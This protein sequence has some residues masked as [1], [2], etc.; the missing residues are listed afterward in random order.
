MSKTIKLKKGYDIKL[1]GDVSANTGSFDTPKTYSVKPTDFVGLSPKLKVEIGAEVKAGTPLFFIKEMPEIMITSPVSGEVIEINRGAKRAILEIKILADSKMAYEQFAM[2]NPGHMDA[3]IVKQTLLNSGAWATIKQ[4]P[5]TKIANPAETPKSIFISGFD[6]S[7]LAPD[8]NYIL[9]G[10]DEDFQWGINALI[11]LTSGKKIYLNLKDGVKACSAFANAKGVEINSFSGP[12]PAGNVGVQ[13]HHIS[14]IS[15]GDIVW[16]VNPEDVANIGKLFKE[17]KYEA[18]RTVALTG[19]EANESARKYYKVK[20]GACVETLLNNNLSA[21]KNRI[22]SGNV[23]TGTKIAANGYLGFYDHQITVI[24]EGENPEFLGWLIPTYSRP[25]IS[26]TFLS[27][28]TPNKKFKVNTN[29][30][31]EE[32]ALVVTGEYEKVLPMDILPQY[33]LKAILAN[34]LEAMEALGLLEL[35]EED[36]ALC[37]FVCTSKMPI[38]KLIREGLAVLEKEG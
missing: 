31:G 2:G 9:N 8:Y 28:L 32:R 7:P 21:G 30:H 5:F 23:L 11:M 13:I 1:V 38:Q 33:L 4:R 3:A 20:A 26:K 25:S 17:G 14:P 24:P 35:D 36:M 29:M 10:R 27:Y 16:T 6:S 18:D 37:E 34:D 15:K 12:H 19:S 22:I